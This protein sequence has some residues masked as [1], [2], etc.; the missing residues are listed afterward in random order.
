MRW[1]IAILAAAMAGTALAQAPVDPVV[2]HF[3]AYRAALDAGEMVKADVEAEAALAA[4]IARDGDGGRTGVLAMNLVQV[5]L[6]RGLPRAAYEPA[7]RA[8]SIVSARGAASGLDPL[9]VRLALGRA[10]LAVSGAAGEQS[11]LAA[12]SEGERRTDIDGPIHAAAAALGVWAAA[13]GRTETARRAW[14]LAGRFAAGSPAGATLARA[15]ARLGEALAII[16]AN[17]ER[18]SPIA[19]GMKFPP[20][21]NYT[22]AEAAL[23]DAI[24]ATEP[25][26]NVA[27]APRD[28]MT[29]AQTIYARA[30]VWRAIMFARLRDEA[31][32]AA[33]AAHGREARPW[34]G[35]RRTAPSANA[36]C[37]ITITAEPKP[38]YPAAALST[39]GVGAV[40]TRT[41][42][43]E[44]G[45]AID[46]RAAAAAPSPRFSGAVGGAAP[47][48]RAARAAGNP[49][50]CVMPRVAFTTT[51]FTLSDR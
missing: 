24:E 22:F 51:M 49:P 45:Q 16:A 32:R 19:V 27:D 44:A 25:L 26:A 37:A 7:L 28:E 40:V 36:T 29:L 13:V 23:I 2:S 41:L 15:E 4:S 35:A 31:D 43:D 14:A 21:G 12:L 50:G 11:L 18:E 20:P 33:L 8:F 42:F 38:Q 17:M 47:L 48:W 39:L 5:R 34:A 10:E 46:I 9:I 1:A 3:R 30:L 6:D